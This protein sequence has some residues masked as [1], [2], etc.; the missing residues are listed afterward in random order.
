MMSSSEPPSIAPSVP[1]KKQDCSSVIDEPYLSSE[2]GSVRRKDIPNESRKQSSRHDNI[3]DTTIVQ[4]RQN[5]N[6]VNDMVLSTD[7][8]H[9]STISSTP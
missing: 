8:V 7:E 1:K 5:T 6:G 2:A 4:P 9:I 3:E